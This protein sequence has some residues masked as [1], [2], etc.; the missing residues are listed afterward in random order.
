MLLVRSLAFNAAFYGWTALLC[1]VLPWTLWLARPRVLAVVCWYLGTVAWLERRVIGLDYEV[2]GREH[3][4]AGGFLVAAKHQSAWET[5]K[6]HLLLDDP[7]I[8][9]KE[10]LMRIPV[11][12]WFAARLGMI[13]VA[14]GTVRALAVL[15]RNAGPVVAAGRPIVVFPQGTRVAPGERHPYRAGIGLL[16]EA[17]AVPIVPMAVNSGLFWGRKRFFKRPGRI[18]VE[19]LPAIPPGLGRLAAMAALEQDLE[20]ATDRLLTE[21]P[22]HKALP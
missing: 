16:Y 21:G 6:L 19:F 12:G 8:V 4:P 22:G 11:W 3:L 13:P 17:L 2:R 14:R 15:R 5:M 1:L 10:E 20:A 9:L 18:T 7:A